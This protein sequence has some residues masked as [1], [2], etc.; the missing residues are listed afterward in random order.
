MFKIGDNVTNNGGKTVPP[1]DG[2][3]VDVIEREGKRP[4]FVRVY[5]RF[6]LGKTLDHHVEELVRVV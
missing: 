2:T 1:W 4:S 5:W 3:I 6:P